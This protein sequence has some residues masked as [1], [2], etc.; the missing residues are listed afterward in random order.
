[1]TILDKDPDDLDAGVAPF[2]HL[3]ADAQKN[4][5]MRG[6]HAGGDL[7]LMTLPPYLALDPRELIVPPSAV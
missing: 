6:V 2:H 3:L 4:T 5:V 1:M 7:T